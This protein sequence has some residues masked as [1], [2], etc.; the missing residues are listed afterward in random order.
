MPVQITQCADERRLMNNLLEQIVPLPLSIKQKECFISVMQILNG[1][2]LPGMDKTYMAMQDLFLPTLEWAADICGWMLEC[3][4]FI[5]GILDPRAII[6]TRLSS[7]SSC[8][9]NGLAFGAKDQ[10]VREGCL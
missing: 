4:H 5:K 2:Y 3:N 6:I 7:S 8:R 10:R 9:R 1:F